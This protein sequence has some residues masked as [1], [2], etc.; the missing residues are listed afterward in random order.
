MVKLPRS[1]NQYIAASASDREKLLD[2]NRSP[3]PSQ[4]KV[5]IYLLLS[6]VVFVRTR[7]KVQRSGDFLDIFGATCT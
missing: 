7:V 5:V 3:K 6:V 2:K 1:E 4:R